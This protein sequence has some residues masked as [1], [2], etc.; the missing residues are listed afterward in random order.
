MI[1]PARC[2]TQTWPPPQLRSSHSLLLIF[3]TFIVVAPQPGRGVFTTILT[4][5]FTHAHFTAEVLTPSPDANTRDLFSGARGRHP[6]AGVLLKA[7]LHCTFHFLQRTTSLCADVLTAVTSVKVCSNVVSLLAGA[8]R[9]DPTAG[10]PRAH[11]NKTSSQISLLR[12]HTHFTAA[13]LTPV[14]G[15]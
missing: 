12:T 7:P 11:L 6:R 10:V 1:L 3:F 13:M 15:C 5:R 4:A 2:V 8:T 14:T 9:R